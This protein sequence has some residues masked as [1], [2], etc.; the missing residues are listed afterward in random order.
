MYYGTRGLSKLPPQ[1]LGIGIRV[2]NDTTSTNSNPLEKPSARTIL[3]VEDNPLNMKLFA[4]LLSTQGYNVLQALTGQA[5]LTMA[6]EHHP[7]L[8]V[9][10]VQLPGNLSGLDVTRSLKGDDRYKSIPVIAVT[11]FAMKG[12][13]TKVVD[14]GCDGYITKPISIA[15]FLASITEFLPQ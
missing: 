2:N 10:D 1:P 4:D 11:A 3:V 9:M 8:I 6:Q 7:D 13:E 12:D 15:R 14:A 5:G